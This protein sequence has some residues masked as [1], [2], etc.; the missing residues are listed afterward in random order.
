MKYYGG[1]DLKPSFLEYIECSYI[2]DPEKPSYNFLSK[3]KEN[4]L[5][6]TIHFFIDQIIYQ[7]I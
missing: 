1:I 5:Q 3:S 4:K 6:G 2:D 7:T